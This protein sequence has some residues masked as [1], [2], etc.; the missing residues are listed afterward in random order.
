MAFGHVILREFHLDR[1]VEYFADYCR[2]YTD[3]PMLVRLVERDGL[4][5]PERL[6]AG[7]RSR[8][9]GGR[10]QQPRMEAPRRRRRDRLGGR[11]RGARRVPVGRAG[12]VEPRAPGRGGP[13]GKGSACHLLDDRDEVVA[14]GFPYFGNLEHAHFAGT[15]HPSVL[16]RNVPAKRLRLAEE[17]CPSSPPS[18]ISCSRTTGSPGA[19]RGAHRQLLDDLEP[20]TPAWA[21]AITGIA[22]DR[23]A[24]VARGFAGKRGTHPR[25]LDGSSGRR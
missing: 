17:R 3:L 11:P 10:G 14:V 12:Q 25:P 20:Y 6:P 18:T 1:Q 9:R 13:R 22:R 21:E 2:R 16:V 4:L 8:G 15:D 24:S 7:L 5:V 19:R 23:I